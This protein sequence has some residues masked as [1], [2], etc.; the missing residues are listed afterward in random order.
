MT[1]LDGPQVVNGLNLLAGGG[2]LH[3]GGN[4]AVGA[5]VQSSG[6][7]A[8]FN[9]FVTTSN[10]NTNG[11]LGGYATYGNDADN[12]ATVSGG[13]SLARCQEPVTLTLRRQEPPTM[14][15]VRPSISRRVL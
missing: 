14:R 2:T 4:F 7:T 11:I 5:I 1:N 3:G 10:A 8:N 15:A 12:W 9:G 6:A 13:N